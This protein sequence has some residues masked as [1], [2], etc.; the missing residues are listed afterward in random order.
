MLTN[1]AVWSPD[2]KWIA[3]DVRSKEDGSVFDGTRIER[4]EVA[5][6]RVEVLYESRY[7]ACCGVV[8]ASPIDDR[9][10]FI[11][12]PEHPAADWTYGP[13]RRKGMVV[14]AVRPGIAEPLDA[15]DLV[16]PFTPGAL[17]GGTHVHVF[18]PDGRLVSFTYEDA[19]L[20]GPGPP[21][22]QR[23]L[24]GVGVSACG[25][26]VA[27]PPVHSRNHDGT[28]FSVLVTTLTDEPRPGSDEI[29][30]ACEEGWVGEQGYLRADGSRQRRALAFQGRVI[31]ALG[32]SIDEVFLVDLPEDPRAL[33]RPG[34]EPL[35]GNP[36]TRPSVPVGLAQRRL[37]FTADRKHPG[38]QG[39][40][41]WLR[42]NSDG[43]RIAFL[44]RDDAG[45]AQLFT[46]SPTGGQPIQVTNNAFGIESSFTWTPDGKHV[47]CV[48]D[49]SV[50]L[51]D[52]TTG[53]TRRLTEPVRDESGPRPEACVV[54]PDGRLITFVRSVGDQPPNPRHTHLFV[55]A[56]PAE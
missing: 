42:S 4:V 51:V 25:R 29:C 35:A 54:S 50:C 2:S 56:R 24:R 18:S 32:A 6:G 47:A 5:T 39:P 28:A 8:T 14:R 27:V 3:Y 52:M 13:A 15:R 10:V 41:H 55:V 44:M 19:V 34:H 48:A 9:L 26:P 49:G 33:E 31:T 43:S 36:T 20:D 37:T 53:A 23:N 7:G 46:I 16:P 21:G 11:L 1:A 40:R 38:I 17:R 12:G 30:R 45:V 22:R